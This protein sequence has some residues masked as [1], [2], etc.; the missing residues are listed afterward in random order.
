MTDDKR[1]PVTVEALMRLKRVEQPPVEFWDQFDKELRVKQLAAIVEKRPWWHSFPRAYGLVARHPLAL[2]SA[3]ALTIALFSV[4]EFHGIARG[5]AAPVSGDMAYEPAAATA[6][7]EIPS[8]RASTPS[9]VQ[10]GIFS[11]AKPAVTELAA[12][13]APAGRV[14]TGG[15]FAA[16][17]S[18]SIEKADRMTF[19][20]GR[21]LVAINMASIQAS[22]PELIRN[23]L[24]F[25]QGFQPAASERHQVLEPLAQM[26]SPSDERRARLHSDARPM[27]ASYE[28]QSFS[29]DGIAN[30]LSDDRVY[31]SV[32]R[33]GVGGD[34]LSIKF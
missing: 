22:E 1:H 4:G 7:V 28:S 20:P 9:A 24:N 11:A 32:S 12:T 31:E 29:D 25:A 23:T 8:A 17:A 6:R 16:D 5:P 2:G 30:R 13:V 14:R 21:S 18:L 10:A 26:T 34:R 33:Y 3:A 19:S 15:S 27:L